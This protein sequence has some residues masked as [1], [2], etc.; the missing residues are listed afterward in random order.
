MKLNGKNLMIKKNPILLTYYITNRCN[1]KC[2]FCNIWKQENKKDAKKGDVLE[3]LKT[4]KEELKIKF[5]D[6]TGGEPLLH[7]DIIEILTYAKELNLYTSITTNT[8]LY[9]RMAEQLNNK[10]DFLLF[11]ID[12]T[13]EFHNQNRGGNFF[14][15]LLESIEI[16][17][18]LNENPDLIYTVTNESIKYID[19][20]V[21]IGQKNNLMVQINPVF[22][23]FENEPI[24]GKNLDIIRKYF[25]KKNVYVNLAQLKLIENNGNNLKKPRCRGVTS[26]LVISED[27][28]IILPCY[29]NMKWE[30]DINHDLKKAFNS[31]KRNEIEKQQGTFPFCQECTINCYFDPSF[32]YEV[33]K[34]MFWSLLSRIKYSCEKY[35]INKFRR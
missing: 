6:F 2:D 30:I 3:N 29:H 35:F 22:E 10:V 31:K 14:R 25:W 4:A 8:K 16:A 15:S 19:D 32:E 18:K 27:N 5:V 24:T 28:K 20:V 17:K 13:R 11:S 9:P 21:E 33:D 12:G 34:Y 26:N 1:A 23:Y 7:N